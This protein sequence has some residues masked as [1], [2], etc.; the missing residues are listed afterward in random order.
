MVRRSSASPPQ[1]NAAECPGSIAIERIILLCAFYFAL[2]ALN[3]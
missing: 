2:A 3:G 1:Q